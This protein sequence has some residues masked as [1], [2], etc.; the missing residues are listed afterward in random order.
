MTKQ[1]LLDITRW[2]TNNIELLIED[3]TTKRIYPIKDAIYRM[4]E[5]GEGQCV[6]TIDT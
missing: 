1:E 3:S 6:L 2:F 4:T 5:D